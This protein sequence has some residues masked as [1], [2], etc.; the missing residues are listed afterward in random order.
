M[1]IIYVTEDNTKCYGV[2]F[3]KNGWIN[4]QKY[5]YISDDKNTI[6]CLKPLEFFWVKA[7]LV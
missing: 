6:Y 2:T 4:V 3:Q 1:T 5:E 7:S